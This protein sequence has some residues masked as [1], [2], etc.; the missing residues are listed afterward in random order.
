MPNIR[1]EKTG[2]IIRGDDAGSYVKIIDDRNNTGGYLV[3][4]SNSP[5]FSDGYD[6]WV[7]SVDALKEYFQE[8]KWDIQW[9]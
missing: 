5:E 7:E 8:S 9:R 3:L 1:I 6:D 4:V 2:Q